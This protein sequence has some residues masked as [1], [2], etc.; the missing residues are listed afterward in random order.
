MDDGSALIAAGAGLLSNYVP[1]VKEHIGVP[2]HSVYDS[3]VTSIGHVSGLIGPNVSY[4]V[5]ETFPI[6]G[7][8][9]TALGL[10]TYL[11]GKDMKKNA[12]S[13]QKIERSIVDEILSELK[14]GDKNLNSLNADDIYKKVSKKLDSE[15]TKH[16]YIFKD[17][18]QKASEMFKA[19]ELPYKDIINV[20][21]DVEKHKTLRDDLIVPSELDRISAYL[22]ERDLVKDLK[23][24]RAA[25]N[26]LAS[27]LHNRDEELKAKNKELNAKKMMLD[28]IYQELANKKDGSRMGPVDPD[29]PDL[30]FV[31]LT[32][33]EKKNL[34][35]GSLF[36][37][38]T[39]PKPK[40]TNEE[41]LK[42]APEAFK[43]HAEQGKGTSDTSRI[44]SHINQRPDT[45][46]AIDDGKQIN[47]SV[48]YATLG[49]GKQK[50]PYNKP[51]SK[52]G[53]DSL[54]GK[55]SDTERISNERKKSD[56][57]YKTMFKKGGIAGKY[58]GDFAGWKD[59]RGK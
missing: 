23:Y 33:A 36:A 57:E 25:K 31:T 8:F 10:G 52:A 32:E 9:L 29:K 15:S 34:D 44:T 41:H 2:V 19:D 42:A 45:V 24:N 26:N 14:D 7:T 22:R 27:D 1:T 20:L 54:V 21:L 3:A 5:A 4:N 16:G 18:N 55:T 28:A 43:Y 56:S 47:E 58:G 13:Y 6:T 48:L 40:I 49:H 50:D 12:K 30:N 11:K 37:Y 35:E 17:V 46:I 39:H 53:L 38:L 51:L 59:S